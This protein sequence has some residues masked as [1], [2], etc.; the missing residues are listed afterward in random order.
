MSPLIKVP[1]PRDQKQ[2]SAL[3]GG[4]GYYRKFLPDLSNRI[5]P[6]TSLLSERVKFEFTPAIEVIV[7]EILAELATPPIL[8]FPE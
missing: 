7:S 2:V 1:M 6:I 4:V 8:I 5:R 3:S